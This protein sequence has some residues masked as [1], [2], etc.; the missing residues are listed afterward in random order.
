MSLIEKFHERVGHLV[1]GDVWNKEY[2][3]LNITEESRELIK[4]G[5]RRYRG[6][7]RI[8]RGLFHTTE[9]R[10]RLMDE[11]LSAQLP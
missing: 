4:K 7:V 11:L 6:S 8:S 10:K 5:R 1:E 9:E 3:E 2:A